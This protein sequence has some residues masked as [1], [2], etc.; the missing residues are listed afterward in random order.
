MLVGQPP[1]ETWSVKETHSRIV[2]NTYTIPKSMSQP[3]QSLI[4]QLLAPEPHQRPT[5]DQVLEHE[6]FISG[7]MPT[8]IPVSSWIEPPNLIESQSNL[9]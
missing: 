3:A 7:H 1:F 6:F 4:R 2:G 9:K 8:S 5:L